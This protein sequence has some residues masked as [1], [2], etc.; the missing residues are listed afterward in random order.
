MNDDAALLRQ[1]AD[2]GSEAAFAELVRRHLGLVYHAALRQTNG[3]THRA[4]DVAQEVFTSLARKARTLAQRPTLAGWLHTSTRYA[5]LQSLRTERRRQTREQEAYAMTDTLRPDP[6]D[7]EWER[8][9]PFVDEALHSLNERDREAVLL[10]FFEGRPFAEVGAKLAVTEDAA[11]VRV[12]RALDKLRATLARHGVTST[13]AALAV[14]LATQAGAAA[15]AGLAATITGGA[16]VAGATPVVI[17]SLM[18]LTKIKIALALGVTV[19]GATAVVV[20]HQTNEVLRAEVA[21]LSEVNP[22][23]ANLAAENARLKV[24]I[25]QLQDLRKDDSALIE[26]MGEESGMKTRVIESVRKR[27]ASSEETVSRLAARLAEISP[28]DVTEL[29]GPLVVSS[30]TRPVYPADLKAAGVAGEALIEFVVDT[31][32][33]VIEVKP[34]SSTH[35][36]FEAAAAE[37]LMKWKFVPGQK[38]GQTVKIHAQQPFK[39][40]LETN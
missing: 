29:D 3:D 23:T 34:V 7:A 26:L 6:S 25:A 15:P 18:N 36:E 32:G 33:A 4:Q 39:F 5:A 16:L 11:R 35:P 10:R 12:D 17:F 31:T 20:Q 21:R 37:A 22:S 8:L 38:G 28:Y 40:T 24:S 30:V 14:T 27:A 19:A 9:K 1:Y 13:A 2:Q